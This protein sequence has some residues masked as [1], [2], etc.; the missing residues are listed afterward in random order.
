MR[1]C[2]TVVLSLAL[3]LSLLLPFAGMADA[4]SDIQAEGE[5][6]IGTEGTW[7]PWCYHDEEDRLVGFDV[8]VAQG[9]AAKLGVTAVFAE[10]E[11]DGLFAGLNARRYDLICNG[12]EISPERAEKYNFTTPY[13]YMRTAILVREDDDRIASYDDL[14][15]MVTANSLGST[16]EALAVSYGAIPQTVDSLDQTISLLIAGRIDATLNAEVS[17]ADYMRVHPEA[18]IKVAALTEESTHVSIPV[19]KEAD[20]D[21]LLEA[22]NKAL[23]EMRAEGEL[24]RL[25]EKYFGVDVTGEQAQ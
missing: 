10:G 2:M 19:R 8:E 7:A 16:Y 5:L 24:S 25:S 23:E 3:C 13:A 12:V 21:T 11:W 20:C 1:K 17:F 9:I 4:L 18:P 22:V 15:G 6:V 14:K